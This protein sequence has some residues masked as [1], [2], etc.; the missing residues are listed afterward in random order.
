MQANFTALNNCALGIANGVPGNGTVYMSPPAGIVSPAYSTPWNIFR[1]DGLA[2]NT[3]GTIANGLDSVFAD[4]TFKQNWSLRVDGTGGSNGSNT[5][6]G[7]NGALAMP[8][9]RNQA[10]QLFGASIYGG[11]TATPADVITVDSCLAGYIGFLG[12]QIGAS[13]AT[14]Y[15]DGTVLVMPT[16]QV[17]PERMTL[18]SCPF[19]MGVVSFDGAA[20][21]ST[22]VFDMSNGSILQSQFDIIEA[23]GSGATVPKANSAIEIRNPTGTL[24]FF[25]NHVHVG[26]AHG[27]KSTTVRIGTVATFQVNIRENTWDFD[28]IDDTTAAQVGLSTYE[29]YGKYRIGT[30]ANGSAVGGIIGGTAMRFESG[31]TFNEASLTVEDSSGAGWTNGVTFAANSDWNRVNLYT[32]GTVTNPVVDTAAAHNSWSIN[33]EV[34]ENWQGTQ[35]WNYVLPT[36]CAANSGA[37]AVAAGSTNANG[38][39]TLSGG[40]P[41]TVTLTF[42]HTYKG[43]T[44][45]APATAGA[46]VGNPVGGTGSVVWTFPSSAGTNTVSYTACHGE[47]T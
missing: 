37:C 5:W 1:P 4:T 8:P 24:G 29:S 45:C 17:L 10:V 7:V 2:Q 43:S 44:V 34:I 15:T 33:G 35:E 14:G 39:L 11:S 6:I 28:W 3:S 13:P 32:K 46:V 25:R 47:G 26:F 12:N 41:T 16:N 38:K 30:I 23:N 21:E 31:A 40:T 19:Y 36:S 18:F 42:S 27:T 22:I 9:L 20:G